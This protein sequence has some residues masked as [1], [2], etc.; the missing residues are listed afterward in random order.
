MNKSNIISII[1][2]IFIIGIYLVPNF[3][4]ALQVTINKEEFERNDK[5][6]FNI[7]LLDFRE[8]INNITLIIDDKLI[9]NQCSY[10]E[11]KQDYYG[12]GYGY[13]DTNYFGYGYGYGYGTENNYFEAE[14]SYSFS[15]LNP[16]DYN[17][18]IVLNSEY[19]KEGS[20][21]V[22]ADGGGSSGSSGGYFLPK[23]KEKEIEIIEER[24][25]SQKEIKEIIE[26]IQKE[27]PPITAAVVG[28]EGKFNW[29]WIFNFYNLIIILGIIGVVIIRKRQERK[30]RGINKNV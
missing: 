1:L 6:I 26:E 17:Y 4:S 22:K 9:C 25:E 19:N 23:E 21:K 5:I 11:I 18:K 29:K 7:K 28:T 12:Y 14:L 15:D 8:R 2:T 27:V 13:G 16:G 24:I 30:F 3:A 20:F 10:Q